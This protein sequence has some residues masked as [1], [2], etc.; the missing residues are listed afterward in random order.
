[1]TLIDLATR[2]NLAASTVSKVENGQMSPTY[3]T[4]LALADGLDIDIG[5]LVT[6]GRN[7]AGRGRRAVQRA[8]EGPLT[9]NGYFNIRHL[10]N[11]IAARAFVPY[12]V[13]I[14]AN[15][16]HEFP[17]LL[18]HGGEEFIFVLSGSVS[19]HTEFYAPAD[20]EVGDC[21]YFD[22]TMGHAI[23]NESD[24]PAQIIWVCSRECAPLPPRKS[25]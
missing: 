6:G 7:Q 18:T 17:G 13:T 9:Q 25:F 5:D 19:L 10:C 1:M 12:H 24:T 22:S 4:L 20:L 23:C 11:D 15:D 21:A 14:N 16:L 8:G 3:D 2:S